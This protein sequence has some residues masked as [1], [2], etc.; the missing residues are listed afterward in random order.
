MLRGGKRVF[1]FKI[2]PRDDDEKG[3]QALG[4][5]DTLHVG[6]IS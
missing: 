5:G 4:V 3:L 2:F 6:R 1:S